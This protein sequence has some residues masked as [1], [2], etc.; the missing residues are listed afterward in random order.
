MKKKKNIMKWFYFLVIL[1]LFGNVVL[2]LDASNLPVYTTKNIDSVIKNKMKNRVEYFEFRLS[3]VDNYYDFN[4]NEIY[5]HTGVAIE[6]DYLKYQS[7]FNC[8]NDWD[9]TNNIQY[10]RCT[11]DYPTNKDEENEINTELKKVMSLMALSG[12]NYDKI[13]TIYTWI[14]NNVYLDNSYNDYYYRYGEEPPASSIY[15][16]LINRTANAKGMAVLFYRMALE[17]GLEA[18]VINGHRNISIA[19]DAGYI[20]SGYTVASYWNMVKLGN[21][22]YYIDLANDIAKAKKENF[23]KGR[24]SDRR[25]YLDDETVIEKTISSV[26]YSER[27]YRDNAKLELRQNSSTKVWEVYNNGKLDTK[28]TGM[29]TNTNGTYYA[30]NGK[31]SL[32]YNGSYKDY[33]DNI[34][35]LRYSKVN[36]SA[37]GLQ[38]AKNWYYFEKGKS[39]NKYN[40]VAT[41]I[42]GT[43]YVDNGMV[44]FNHNELVYYNG[45]WQPFIKSRLSTS[46]NGILSNKNGS[47]YVEKGMVTFKNNGTYEDK[48][49]NTI[50]IL[51]NSKVD[52]T[53]TGLKYVNK[54]WYYFNKGVIDRN[55][56]G[57]VKNTNGASYYVE[58]GKVDF[59]YNGIYQSNDG[60]IYMLKNGRVDTTYNGLNEYY[61]NS[62][63]YYFKNGIVDFSYSGIVGDSYNTY[64][65][66]KGKVD[67]NFTDIITINNKKYYIYEGMV[68][69]NGVYKGQNGYICYLI[70]GRIDTSFTGIRSYNSESYYFK[71]GVVDNTYTG[72]VKEDEYS[73]YAYYVKEGKRESTYTGIVTVDN[74]KYYVENGEV[75]LNNKELIFYNKKW[76]AVVDGKINDN[77]TGI[78][79][80]SN[81]T[82]LVENGIIS[83]KYNGLYTDENGR[84]YNI[85][86]SKYDATVNG[87]S[88]V[89][90]GEYSY[91]YYFKNGI[92]SRSNGIAETDKGTIYYVEDGIVTFNYNDAYT[93]KGTAYKFKNSKV[94]TSFTGL[95]YASGNDYGYWYFK[96][97]VAD[98][99]YTG[100]ACR[101][102][103]CYNYSYY[104]IKGKVDEHYTGLIYHDGEWKAI[105]DGRV[106][107]YYTGIIGNSNGNYYMEN[108][109]I[110]FKYNGYYDA[111]GNIYIIKNGKVDTS[112]TGLKYANNRWLYFYKGRTDYAY[113]GVA[114]NDNGALYYVEGGE[115]TFNYN[116]T[117]EYNG[118]TYTVKNSKLVL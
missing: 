38:Y 52:T 94:D 30:E 7:N 118:K 87:L 4:R 22:Y 111:D 51:K 89:Y 90:E 71:N 113:T 102:N 41:N 96:N 105:E 92:V 95:D 43:Y 46:Y 85:K 104:V 8:S 73:S 64:Y 11:F 75:N 117:V 13:N 114:S 66:E 78:A 70:N 68:Y 63:K 61:Y 107:R 9:N 84:K 69:T 15:G 50:Y 99:T 55:Y 77:Y 5:K 109:E 29:V 76:T 103:D 16:A 19:D 86:N 112:V 48:K 110:S 27:V 17:A 1:F 57:I 101:Y 25:V 58:S 21:Y 42:N 32:K 97:G 74:E 49:N 12:S 106:N 80:N 45:K 59:D 82:Y 98:K 20:G 91:L 23:L 79:S 88:W 62:N 93:Y 34:Y 40:G 54:T 31:V 39:N 26:D 6:G 60:I 81:G 28:Y 10:Y 35:L 24:Y 65:V 2:A 108:G 44:T 37:N 53:Y 36:T 14:V 83:F 72:I 100:I 47:Y 18:R 115:V 3:D 33:L 116:G 67:R 56:R